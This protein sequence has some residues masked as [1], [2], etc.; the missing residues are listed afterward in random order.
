MIELLAPAGDLNRLK[1]AIDYGA[2]AI[3]LGGMSFGLRKGATNFTREEMIEGVKYAHERNKKVYVT[4]NIIPHEGDTDGIEEY[5][6]FLEDIGVDAV[7]VSD[8]GIFN[9]VKKYSNLEI[10]ISTQGS[11][12]NAATAN[13]WYE[14]GAKRIVLARE[15][16][17]DEIKKIRENIPDDM[18]LEAFCH[19]AMCMSYSGRCLI[20]SYMTGRDANLGDCAHPCRYKYYLMEEKRPGEYF[21][22][23][24]TEGGT[25]LMN[26]RDLKTI[27]FIDKLIEAGIYSL[28][29]EGRIKSAFYIATILRAYRSAID[30]YMADPENYKFDEIWDREVLMTS[31][32]PF[33]DG[34]FFGNPGGEGQFSKSSAYTSMSQYKG[35]VVKSEDGRLYINLKN[36]INEGDELEMIGPKSSCDLKVCD[37]RDEKFKQV[38]R[39]N[40]PNSI[41]SIKY[42]G[43]AENNFFIR[44]VVKE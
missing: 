2:D 34:F 22:I 15:L 23:E 27:T 13:F 10:H 9:K 37:L 18:D 3:Y 12:T 28:K 40:I 26:S 43:E 39:A 29:I 17:L 44:K 4:L 33:T 20:S 35:D 5:I 25:Y 21:P 11:V 1:I 42:D 16:S 24:E 6:V 19:G 31:H 7:I 30:A 32:R 14:L 41:Y 8:P 38:E 36:G